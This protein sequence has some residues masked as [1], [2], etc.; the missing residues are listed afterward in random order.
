MSAQRRRGDHKALSSF[1]VSSSQSRLSF[2]KDFFEWMKS[3]LTLEELFMH[4]VILSLMNSIR[5]EHKEICF[6]FLT[7]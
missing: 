5:A 2:Q 4:S 6:T 1:C 3:A 7:Y